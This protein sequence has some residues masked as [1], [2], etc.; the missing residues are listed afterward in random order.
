MRKFKVEIACD[1]YLLSGRDG[2]SE[3][4]DILQS[5]RNYVTGEIF[6]EIVAL[7]KRPL[8]DGNGNKVGHFQ[9]TE[10]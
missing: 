6:S 10:K 2:G 9:A 7:G 1:D 3:I 8:T 4:A 5:V